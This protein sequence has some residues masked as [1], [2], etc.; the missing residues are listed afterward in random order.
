MEKMKMARSQLNPRQLRMT[1]RASKREPPKPKP[2]TKT[3][4]LLYRNQL[5]RTRQVSER[6]PL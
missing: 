4:N 2:V 6:G 5:K 1:R 3:R